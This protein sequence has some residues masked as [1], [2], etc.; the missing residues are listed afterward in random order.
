MRDSITTPPA[1]PVA[2]EAGLELFV[3]HGST[4]ALVE[5]AAL[6]ARSAVVVGVHGAALANVLFCVPGA[7]LVELPMKEPCFRD[8]AH[9]SM[10]LGLQYFILDDVPENAYHKAV[11]VEPARLA[12]VVRAAAR[13][14]A[15]AMAALGGAPDFG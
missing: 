11:R 13:A 9:A 14:A 1:G 6:F 8:Y 2:A 10:A 12:A 7:A 3:F 4:V 15:P 5:A